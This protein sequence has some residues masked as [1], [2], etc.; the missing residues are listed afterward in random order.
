MKDHENKTPGERKTEKVINKKKTR[1]MRNRES[2]VP[3]R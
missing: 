2:K 1:R 3:G